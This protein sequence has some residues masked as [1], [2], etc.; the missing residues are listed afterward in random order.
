MT[1]VEELRTNRESGAKRLEAEYKAG[2]MTLARRFCT[3]EGDAEELV[4][5][6]F[7]AVVE[8]IDD[9]LEQSAF[10]GWMCQILSNIHAKDIRK[11]SH[12]IVV[13]PGVVPDV[14]DEDAED[15]IFQ[16]IDASLLH[17]AIE[18]LPKEMQEAIVLHYFTGLSVQKIAKFLAIPEGTVKSR[19]HYARLALGAKL[20][21]NMKKPGGKAVLLALLLCGLT[22]LGAA[23]WNLATSGEAQTPAD[24]STSLTV[25][26][27]AGNSYDAG[28]AETSTLYFSN[29]SN[30][31]QSPSGVAGSPQRGA[32]GGATFS[33][34]ENMNITQ[35][36]HAAAMLAAGTIA[37]AAGGDEY[38]YIV[39]GDPDVAA[40][41][42]S[43]S[44]E[45][46]TG[47]LDVRHHSAAESS[48]MALTSIKGTGFFIVVR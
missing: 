33:Q 48:T 46:T 38:Q 12:G 4:N 19:L 1:I 25:G 31:P 36:T 7:A 16:E 22:A 44:A 29:S 21:A 2:L 40:I 37:L 15:R 11:K 26:Q 18:N 43:T 28:Q 6:T 3:D 30:L 8:G 32:E 14:I 27:Q 23:A 35:T 13:Y 20:G 42:G 10:F 39:S 47:A 24:A 41:A 45:S 17:D 9:Y 34:G 5:R